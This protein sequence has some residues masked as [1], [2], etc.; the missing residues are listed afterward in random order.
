VEI[1]ELKAYAKGLPY[2]RYLL[3]ESQQV[4]L[5]SSHGVVLARVPVP[6]RYAVHKLLI[7]Q[8]RSRGSKPVKDLHQAAI[9]TAVLAERFPGAIQDALGAVPKSAVKY[10]RRAR[11]A[12]ATHLPAAAETAWE[13]LRSL[14]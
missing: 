7:S 14:A 1:P 3:G 9:L 8:L 6:E 11:Q 13:S 2:L 5:L 12:L 10:L 4:P